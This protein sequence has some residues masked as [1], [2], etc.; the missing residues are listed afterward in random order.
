MV[1]QKEDDGMGGKGGRCRGGR[2]GRQREWAITRMKVERMRWRAR[3][4]GKAER[5]AVTVIV[6][7]TVVAG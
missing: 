6:R 5:D 7:G 2:G 3:A 4:A 1:W